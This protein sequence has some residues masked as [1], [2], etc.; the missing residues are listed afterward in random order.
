MYIV[1][2]KNPTTKYEEVR[3]V[4]IWLNSIRSCDSRSNWSVLKT[5]GYL[6]ELTGNAIERF[7][8]LYEIRPPQYGVLGDLTY[9]CIREREIECYSRIYGSISATP[10]Y[11]IGHQIKTNFRIK[12]IELNSAIK[13]NI[14][15]TFVSFLEACFDE[16]ANFLKSKTAKNTIR[17]AIKDIKPLQDAFKQLVNQLNAQKLFNLIQQKTQKPK[18]EIQRIVKNIGEG[19]KQKLSRA[20]KKILKQTKSITPNSISN[21]VSK[22]ISKT[23]SGA[24]KV[25]GKAMKWLSVGQAI[26]NFVSVILS[27]E[28]DKIE[29]AFF[30][31]IDQLLLVAIGV[32]VGVGIT[33]LGITVGWVAILV[34]VVA[35]I[36][37]SLIYDWLKDLCGGHPITLTISN[38][39]YS[40]VNSMEFQMLL[41][42]E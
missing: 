34:S 7:Q 18:E 17:Q 5:D 37:V 32:L 16:A 13:Q 29:A 33:A 42:K 30:E 24:A 8:R 26:L 38:Q 10:N 23:T 9:K 15:D 11:S 25:G 36:V 4:Q 40:W 2:Q 20:V 21:K 19:E 41:S 28:E 31:I 1:P 6:G 27:G 35:A 12:T 3:Q 14:N 39:V 22:M